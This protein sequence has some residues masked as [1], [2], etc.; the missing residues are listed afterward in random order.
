VARK[1]YFFA[2]RHDLLRLCEA[3]EA[4][5]PLTYARAGPCKGPKTTTYPRARKIPG[6]GRA[7]RGDALGE[8]SFLVLDRTVPVH[9]D[10]IRP[11]P[12]APAV[13][14]VGS[15]LNREAINLSPGG[16]YQ[17]EAIIEGLITCFANT[18]S[19]I[20]LYGRFQR[21][22]RKSFLRAKPTPGRSAYVG[23]GAVEAFRNGIR[24]T[25]SVRSPREWDFKLVD[26]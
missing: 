5:G 22:L 24:L 6:F 26:G 19:A 7:K 11:A 1:T 3:V 14:H 21:A 10:P 23:P 12:N 15:R 16:D 13:Y 18:Q 17:G 8:E 25:Q 4:R 20:R 9:V 2:T